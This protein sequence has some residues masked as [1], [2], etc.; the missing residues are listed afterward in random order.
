MSEKIGEMTEKLT[1]RGSESNNGA[2]NSAFQMMESSRVLLLLIRGIGI[3]N[4]SR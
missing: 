4:A 2:D 3:G 1:I